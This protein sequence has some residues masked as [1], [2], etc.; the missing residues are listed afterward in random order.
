MYG[1]L[2]SNG[3]LYLVCVFIPMEKMKKEKEKKKKKGCRSHLSPALEFIMY[4]VVYWLLEALGQAMSDSAHAKN[5]FH[6]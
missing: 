2:H 5:I 1:I 3:L 6:Y 4:V